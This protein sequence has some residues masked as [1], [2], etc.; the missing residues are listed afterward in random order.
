[1]KEWCEALFRFPRLLLLGAPLGDFE[2]CY[3]CMIVPSKFRNFSI[4]GN[5]FLVDSE[6]KMFLSESSKSQYQFEMRF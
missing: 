2:A 1:M 6:M 5:P 4:S 3:K